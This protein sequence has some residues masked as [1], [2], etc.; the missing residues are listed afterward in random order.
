[1][2]YNQIQFLIKNFLGSN[3]CNF[4]TIFKSSRKI[5]KELSWEQIMFNLDL[6]WIII[7]KLC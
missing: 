7:L 1:M 3:I 5:P 6:R 4:G 2:K